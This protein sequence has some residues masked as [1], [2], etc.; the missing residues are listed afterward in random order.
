MNESILIHYKNGVWRT[1]S[2]EYTN[3]AVI[4]RH[5][6]R[7]K[8]CTCKKCFD[9]PSIQ[10]VKDRVKRM[11]KSIHIEQYLTES[12]AS[13]RDYLDVSNFLKVNISKVPSALPQAIRGLSFMVSILHSPVVFIRRQSE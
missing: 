9:F 12:T 11:E 3:E 1:H 7:G 5:S 8:K 4:V 10:L 2:A 6:K 13:K